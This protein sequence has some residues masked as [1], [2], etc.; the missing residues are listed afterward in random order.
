[1]KLNKELKEYFFL[2]L[3]FVA[4]ILY[5]YFNVIND[6]E[7][8]QFVK[9]FLVPSLLVHYLLNAKKK[10]WVYVLALVFA[11]CGDL[12]LDRGE[13]I[14]E[15]LGVGFFIGFNLLMIVII[16]EKIGVIKENK[17][18]QAFVP[19]LLII[20]SI[21]FFLFD[22]YVGEIRAVIMI[23]FIILA[24]LSSFS[25]YYHLC[26]KTKESLF[27]FLAVVLFFLNNISKGYESFRTA[28]VFIKIMNISLYVI[29]HYLYLKSIDIQKVNKIT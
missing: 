14:T 9:W 17:F 16:S 13:I 26:R 25:L 20:I 12:A 28:G 3:F 7:D 19:L 8:T 10:N 6:S 15:V 18:L 21:I 1:M 2:L 4:A 23:Y 22:D 29:S 5:G 27:F 24:L 11:S